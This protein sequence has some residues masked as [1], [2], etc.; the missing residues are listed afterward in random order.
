MTRGDDE[1]P[2][3]CV[4]RETTYDCHVT[5]S[6]TVCLSVSLCLSVCEIAQ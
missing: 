5:Y 1:G 4:K 2:Y 3:R 6:R